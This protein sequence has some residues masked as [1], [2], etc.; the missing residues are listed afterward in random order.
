MSTQHGV[1]RGFTYPQRRV[2][3]LCSIYG[4][5]NFDRTEEPSCRT[6]LRKGLL[7]KAGAGY[8][9]TTDGRRVVGMWIPR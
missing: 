4:S 8:R 7:K 5:M 6:L 1:D 3:Q 9:L 2:L